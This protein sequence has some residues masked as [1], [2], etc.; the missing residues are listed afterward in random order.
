MGLFHTLLC[1]F[2]LV[3]VIVDDVYIDH[4]QCTVN[5][6][7]TYNTY[8]ADM[9]TIHIVHTV[10]TVHTVHAIMHATGVPLRAVALTAPCSPASSMFTLAIS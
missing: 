4:G 1:A 6:Y 9:H 5:A 2:L 7:D 8:H 10:H 3:I